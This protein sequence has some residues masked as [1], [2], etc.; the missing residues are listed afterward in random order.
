MVVSLLGS[1][2]LR[3]LWV[4]FVFPWTGS[5]EPV[6]LLSITWAITGAVHIIMFRGDSEKA[7]AKVQGSGPSY[8][9]VDGHHPEATEQ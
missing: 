9:S 6:Y 7:Y 8:L 5:R 3:L 2:V 4:W 1:C